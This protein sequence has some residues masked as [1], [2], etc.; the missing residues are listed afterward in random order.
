MTF[1]TRSVCCHDRGNRF[2]TG[3]AD[4]QE[5]VPGLAK[6]NVHGHGCAKV[7][8]L[9]LCANHIQVHHWLYNLA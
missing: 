3:A 1:S 2:R 6:I 5:L 4:M 7:A 9:F 8:L